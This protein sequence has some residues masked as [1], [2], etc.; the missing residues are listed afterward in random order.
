MVITLGF[1]GTLLYSLLVDRDMEK[2]FSASAATM[3]G[4]LY[5]GIPLAFQ[6]GLK[7]MDR[8]Q[9]GLGADLRVSPSTS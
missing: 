7:S 6:V 1:I 8:T 3:I 2:G 5:L 4:A 9:A